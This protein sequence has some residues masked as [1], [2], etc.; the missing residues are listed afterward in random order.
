MRGPTRGILLA[1][2]AAAAFAALAGQ[3][4]AAT[5]KTATNQFLAVYGSPPPTAPLG[6][7]VGMN[8]GF[9]ETMA[10]DASQL[11]GEP[12]LF[13]IAK[14][15]ET[16]LKLRPDETLIDGTLL[17]N[18]TGKN[19][20][21]S[22][23]IQFVDFQKNK[24]TSKLLG[25]T[26][27][28]FPAYADTWDRPWITEICPKGTIAACRTEAQFTSFY[29]G[30][31]HIEAASMLIGLLPSSGMTVQGDL[32]GEWLDGS[33]PC[34]RF[35][36]TPLGSPGLFVSKSPGPGAGFP[37]VGERVDLEKGKA[38]LVSANNDFHVGNTPEIKIANE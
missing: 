4:A 8:F 38:C 36:P 2:L 1:A 37:A 5:M 22:F 29:E 27:V 33:P 13:T 10:F 17:S 3:A 11:S 18:K 30:E 26:E 16:E 34:I 15:K 6:G 28:A 9:G 24:V 7:G 35:Q 14:G 31:V 23:G 21:L 32:W 12:L 19:V 25:V 20:P